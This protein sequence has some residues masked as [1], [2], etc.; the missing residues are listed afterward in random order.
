MDEYQLDLLLEIQ[1]LPLFTPLYDHSF[2]QSMPTLAFHYAMQP[3]VNVHQ[4]FC[5]SW[6]N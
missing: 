6:H 2:R 1:N 4:A 5:L 3:G